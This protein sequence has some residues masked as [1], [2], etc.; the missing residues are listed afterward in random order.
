[1]KIIA[2][3]R[4]ARR[5]YQVVETFEAGVELK[6]NEVKSLRSRSCSITDSF[7]RIERS[8]AFVYSMHIPEFEKSSYLKTEPKRVRRLLLHKRELK[9]LLGLTAQKGFTLVPM[10]VYFNDNGL[11]KIE[12]GLAKGMHTYD[13]RKKIKEDITNREVQRQLKNHRRR[14]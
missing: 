6:G 8:Q 7:V 4:K 11:V 2:T 3:N 10:K 5:N 1:M 14:G 13:K 9:K 12:V